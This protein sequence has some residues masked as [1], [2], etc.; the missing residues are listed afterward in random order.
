MDRNEWSQGAAARLYDTESKIDFA[1]AEVADLTRYL[2]VGRVEQA[3]VARLGQ[4]ALSELIAAQTGLV[5]SRARLL[6]AHQAMLV[7]ARAGGLQWRMNGPFETPDEGGG[8]LP[9]TGHLRQ[10]A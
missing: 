8:S 7:A 5:E 3:F 4:D 10:V 2:A 6:R 9:K 1:I